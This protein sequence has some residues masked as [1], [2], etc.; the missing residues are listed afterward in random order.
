LFAP[1][2]AAFITLPLAPF[3]FG[4]CEDKRWFGS[5]S[6]GHDFAHSAA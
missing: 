2:P 1:V 5:F 4:A 3:Q 6:I